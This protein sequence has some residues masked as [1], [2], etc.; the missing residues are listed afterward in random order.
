MTP[1]EMPNR[2]ELRHE[3]GAPSPRDPGR[4]ASCVTLTES[5]KTEPVRDTR[6][7]SLFLIGGA[8]RP[9]A[10]CVYV[11]AKLATKE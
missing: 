5:M 6:S 10:P 2:A 3:K 11:L 8:V 1:Q 7:A 9:F 4:S